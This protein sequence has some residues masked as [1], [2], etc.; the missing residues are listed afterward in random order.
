MAQSQP[1]HARL[2]M[3]QIEMAGREFS[4]G[5]QLDASADV[6]DSRGARRSV[7]FLIASADRAVSAC[8]Q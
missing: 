3:T 2:W 6:A 5:R 8:L 1:T 4:A 7:T